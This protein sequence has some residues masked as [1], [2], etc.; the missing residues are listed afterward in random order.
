MSAALFFACRT[1]IASKLAPAG[2]ALGQCGS[3][4]A[5]D[6]ALP[7]ITPCIGFNLSL[8][9]PFQTDDRIS[10]YFKAKF[11]ALNR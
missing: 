3:A 8:T 1:A 11:S 4:L 5:R 2:I 6:E 7:D 9:H 10:R